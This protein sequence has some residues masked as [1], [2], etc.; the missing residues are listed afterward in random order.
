M[1]ETLN[2]SLSPK[3]RRGTKPD[4]IHIQRA[5]L[6]MRDTWKKIHIADERREIMLYQCRWQTWNRALFY[7]A[8]PRLSCAEIADSDFVVYFVSK[9]IFL[10]EFNTKALLSAKKLC[11]SAKERY[12]SAKKRLSPKCVCPI[13]LWLIHNIIVRD[14]NTDSV[15]TFLSSTRSCC[16]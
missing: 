3:E 4:A 1:R 13:G 2:K 11:A 5:L 6:F 8:R 12:V 14:T 16:W 7:Y 10:K 15:R 9:A